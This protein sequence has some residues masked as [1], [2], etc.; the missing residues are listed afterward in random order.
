MDD[1]LIVIVMVLGL[2]GLVVTMIGLGVHYEMTLSTM[3]IE[4]DMQWIGGNCVRG[5]VVK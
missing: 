4:A 1:Y 5:E 2:L 3:C